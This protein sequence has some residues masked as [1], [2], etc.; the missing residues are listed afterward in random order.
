MEVHGDEEWVRNY[1]GYQMEEE[2]MD[3][4]V[5]IDQEGDITERYCQMVT[6]RPDCTTDHLTGMTESMPSRR[7]HGKIWSHFLDSCFDRVQIEVNLTFLIVFFGVPFKLS[8]DVI[9]CHLSCLVVYFLESHLWSEVY[10][11][12]LLTV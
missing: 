6:T 3:N 10:I 9:G 5:V 7:R 8:D 2:D 4:R 11:K 1:E 12:F